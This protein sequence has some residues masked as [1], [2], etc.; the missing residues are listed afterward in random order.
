[1]PLVPV[2]LPG[3]RGNVAALM[4]QGTGKTKVILD[5]FGI[6]EQAKD[7]CNLLV[8][9]PKGVYRNWEKEEIPKHLSAD[10]KERVI[11][12]SWKSGAGTTF[13]HYVEAFLAAQNRP[14]ILL[15]NIEALSSVKTALELCETF[16]GRATRICSIGL[17]AA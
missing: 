5:E 11:I 13:K 6:R 2:E 7:L 10:L 3:P 8:V 9:A 1:M 16:I 14:R 12:C 4:E 15:M 17:P